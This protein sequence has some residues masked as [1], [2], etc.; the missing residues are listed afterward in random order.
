MSNPAKSVAEEVVAGS[1]IDLPRY[2]PAYITVVANKWSRSSSARYLRLFEI[3]IVD[4]RLMSLLAIEPWIQASRVDEVV[5]MDKGAV[6]RSLRTLEKR[7]LAMTRR[8]AVDP[9]RREMA[10]TPAGRA[11][12]DEIAE[13]AL[14]RERR[15]LKGFSEQEKEVLLGFLARMRNNVSELIDPNAATNGSDKSLSD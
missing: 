4:W 14:D 15:L 13:I 5:G 2:V 12:H 11:M 9:R 10:L 6:S 1:I 7:G 8:N 3:G